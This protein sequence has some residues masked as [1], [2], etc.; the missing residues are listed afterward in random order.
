MQQEMRVVVLGVAAV[1]VLAASVGAAD[2]IREGKWEFTTEMQMEGMPQMPALP[3]GVKL[4]PG[5][6]VSTRG[7][8]MRSTVV[9]CITKDDLVP[10]SD[11]KTDNKCKTTKMERRGNT[12]NWSTVCTEGEM[13]MTGDGVATYTGEVMDSTM[14]MTTQGQG[15]STKQV[16]KTKGKYLGVCGK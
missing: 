11:Q 12:I 16:V 14:T 5:M 9:K 7:N 4:P 10:G 1:L 2:A 15:Q 13:K 6:S 8:T 3:P